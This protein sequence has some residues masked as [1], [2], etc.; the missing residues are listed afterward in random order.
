MT[1]DAFGSPFFT[2]MIGSD[3]AICG[4]NIAR[5][6]IRLKRIIDLLLLLVR[7]EG[8]E[9]GDLFESV[10]GKFVGNMILLFG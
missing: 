2:R 5:R 6:V 1:I 4:T 7:D 3:E 9:P 8:P 10:S